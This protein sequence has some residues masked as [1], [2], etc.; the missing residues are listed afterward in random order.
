MEIGS[1]S[2]SLDKIEAPRNGKKHNPVPV[3]VEPFVPKTDHNPR[4]LRSW[5]KRTGF[6]SDYSGEAGS[7]ASEKFDSI[8]FNLERNHEQKKG[9]SSPKIEIDPILGRTRR[10]RENEIE[11]ENAPTREAMTRKE[12]ERVLNLGSENQKKIGFRENGNGNAVANGRM[13][14]ESNGHGTS[15]V[16]PVPEVKKEEEDVAEGDVKVNVY[17]NGEE[18]GEGGW[19]RPSGLKCGLR[20]KP[21]FG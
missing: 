12:N 13:N 8:G 16:A 7:S 21:G 18:N 19:Q 20:E 4:E 10:E 3:R 14:R 9:G 2:E 17:E 15:A 6:V 11:Q 5:A 1:S